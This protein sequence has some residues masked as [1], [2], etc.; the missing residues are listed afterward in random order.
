VC[1]IFA[2]TADGE[3]E[4]LI[5]AQDHVYYARH[6]ICP[7]QAV[8]QGET[9]DEGVVR[10]VAANT[11]APSAAPITTT[12]TTTPTTTP[13]ITPTSTTGTSTTTSTVTT[14]TSV[15]N[16]MASTTVATST[17]T[18]VNECGEDTLYWFEAPAIDF[19][20]QLALRVDR[21]VGPETATE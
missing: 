7:E 5:S 16:T 9:E 18:W 2:E 4:E 13:Q 10:A 1:Q 6:K 20:G 21:F 12:T 11:Q 3:S 14:S 19:K 15:T 8:A 17:T